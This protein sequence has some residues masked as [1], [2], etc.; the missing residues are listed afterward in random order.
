[1]SKRTQREI[2][3]QLTMMSFDEVSPHKSSSRVIGEWEVNGLVEKFEEILFR[4]FLWLTSTS[5]NGDP[6]LIINE[7]GFPFRQGFLDS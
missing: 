7:L 6:G 2:G 3:S 5:H 1:M 4:T